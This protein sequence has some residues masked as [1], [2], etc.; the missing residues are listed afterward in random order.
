MTDFLTEAFLRIREKLMGGSRRML[1]DTASA[2]DALQ[3]AFV[4]LWGRYRIQ[5]VQEAEALLNRTV[6]N[7]SVDAL[8]RR[9]TVPLERDDVADDRPDNPGE[10]EA[11]F[12]RVEQ[13]VIKELTETQ[14]YI[15]RRHEYEGAKLETIAYELGMNPPAVRMQLS[16]ARKA[17]RDRYYEQELL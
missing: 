10:R 3:D 1:H 17:I 16:R 15:I 14:Q 5:S 2:E 12:R 11:L 13:L 8:R 7:N 4:K 9:K 6:R